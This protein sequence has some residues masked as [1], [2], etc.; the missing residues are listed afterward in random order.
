M[1]SE[2]LNC[3][4]YKK[5]GR[6]PGGMQAAELGICQA[7]TDASF[8]GINSG[9]CGGRFCWAVAGT[10]CH[11]K[12]QGTFAEDRDS[13]LSCDFF[14][15][16]QAEEG[17]A[18]LRTKFLRFVSLDAKN[19]LLNVMA[20]KHIKSGERF[21]T[22]GEV[23]DT[24]YII[25]RGSCL[26]LVEKEGDLHP[27]DHRG[28]GDIVGM[29]SIL[30]GEPRSAH[31]EAETDMDLWVLNKTQFDDISQKDVE[32]LSFLTEIVADRFDSTRPTAKRRIGKYV[33]TDIIGRGA[34]SIVH[35]G[36]HRELGMP[37]A[38]KMMRHDLVSNSDFLSDFRNEAKIIARLN[39]EN[40][41]K[42][43]DIE[44][45]FRTVFI[46]MEYLEGESLKDILLRLKVIPP[47]LA[48][49]YLIQICFGLDYAHQQG[50]I[51]RD[52]N[53]L[54]IFLQ[55]NKLIKIIDFGLACP[56][57][58]ED[59]HLGGAFPYLAPELFDGE[60]GNQQTDIYAL[61]IT[62][63]EMVVGERPYPEENAS[64]LMKLRRNQDIPDPAGKVPNLP[65]LLRKFILTACR[66]DPTE[67]YPNMGKALEDLKLLAGRV[68]RDPGQ[69]DSSKLNMTTLF[70]KYNESHQQELNQLLEEFRLKVNELGVDLRK[71]DF[72]S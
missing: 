42:V 21:I 11:G 55:A 24:A 44:E 58:F 20:H 30:T 54:N 9:K 47:M 26:V 6:E 65:E 28:E 1:I 71:E 49:D 62:A 46:I 63:Y 60:P 51:H 34:F 10:F 12:V 41:I 61:G 31:V 53:T 33:A 52:I 67:R 15:R 56:I 19:S 3:W 27:V 5:C 35:K 36:V 18:N 32:L 38:I 69:I 68:E 7:S 4:E 57:G 64:A 23:G 50:I 8:N 14:N 2:K 29:M 13:C 66:R 40:I 43:Y 25:Q 45:R 16:V 39:H 59:F 48:V 70:L 22:Q 17:T 37:V 72:F